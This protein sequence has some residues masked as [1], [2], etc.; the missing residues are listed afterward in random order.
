MCIFETHSSENI[1]ISRIQS[2]YLY[3]IEKDKILQFQNK[4]FLSNFVI[5]HIWIVEVRNYETNDRNS[6]IC[7]VAN[8]IQD[9]MMQK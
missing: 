9:D 3:A 5:Y 4:Y 1:D 7:K 8:K 6:R 2:K